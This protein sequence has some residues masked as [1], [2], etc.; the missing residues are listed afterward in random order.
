MLKHRFSTM[1]AVTNS[2]S[3][4]KLGNDKNNYIIH[5]YIFTRKNFVPLLHYYKGT[6]LFIN[7]FNNLLKFK[8]T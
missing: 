6:I 4:R 3:V 1:N 5:I 7:S 8:V 2:E